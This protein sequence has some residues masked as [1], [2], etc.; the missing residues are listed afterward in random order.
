MNLLP[1]EGHGSRSRTPQGQIFE[2]VFAADGG[3]HIDTWASKYHLVFRVLGWSLI[4]IY[5]C[6]GVVIL[7]AIMMA[8]CCRR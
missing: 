6:A 1:I 2:R 3:I 4:Q 7:T 8:F 5:Y